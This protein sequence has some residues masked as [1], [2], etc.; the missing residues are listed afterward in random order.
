[1]TRVSEKPLKKDIF[2]KINNQLVSYIASIRTKKA[3]SI[4]LRELLTESELTMLSKRLAIVVMLER[5]YS[6]SIMQ[7]V[8]QVSPDTIARIA[9]D[10]DRG[11]FEFIERHCRHS[12][13]QKNQEEKFWSDLEVIIRGGMPEMGK[14]RWKYLNK[15]TKAKR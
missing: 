1:M 9:K 8:L 6:Y 14:G 7:S 2:A 4:F 11:R 5:N 3:G 12:I 13:R 15:I 10:K